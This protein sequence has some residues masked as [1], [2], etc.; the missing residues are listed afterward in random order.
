MRCILCII[1]HLRCIISLKVSPSSFIL[2]YF[3]FFLNFFEGRYLYIFKLLHRCS[4]R[5]T[6]GDETITHFFILC[7]NFVFVLRPLSSILS[8]TSVRGSGC[9]PLLNF[10]LVFALEK[11]KKQE[12]LSA[13]VPWPSAYLKSESPE[14]EARVLPNRPP[15]YI[16]LYCLCSLLRIVRI[17]LS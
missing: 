8:F 17:S 4:K 16:F 14:H 11:P 10:L 7:H 15:Y 3:C 6:E 9:Y 12:N 13:A 5:G 1:L 2:F